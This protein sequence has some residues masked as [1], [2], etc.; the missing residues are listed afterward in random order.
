MAGTSG[1]L[2]PGPPPCRWRKLTGPQVLG[3]GRGDACVPRWY[4]HRPRQCPHLPRQACG[5]CEWPR[6]LC[7]QLPVC[8]TGGVPAPTSPA[9]GDPP[10]GVGVRPRRAPRVSGCPGSQRAWWDG[11][12]SWTVL[13]PLER[14]WV[15]R[16][17][18][19]FL[20]LEIDPLLSLPTPPLPPWGQ[21]LFPSRVWM[22]RMGRPAG[23]IDFEI[24]SLAVKGHA[25]GRA[26][27][28][29]FAAGRPAELW[30]FH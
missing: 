14:R 7:L 16:A 11:A 2:L 27:R 24:S 3:T 18:S 13:W 1:L 28:G 9:R 17:D 25:C 19:G 4:T 29:L 26:S 8:E 6:P 15:V 5:L 20:R 10:A 12:E 23:R 30:A 21:G 22:A